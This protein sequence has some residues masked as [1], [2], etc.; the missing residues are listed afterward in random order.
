M[1]APTVAQ[2]VQQL[3]GVI[4]KEAGKAIWQKSFHDHVIRCQADFDEIA[5]YID[6]NPLNWEKDCFYTE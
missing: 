6:E 1:V 2:V 5:R 3:K 4:S